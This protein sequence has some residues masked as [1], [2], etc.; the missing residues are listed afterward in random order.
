VNGEQ[1]Y[2][3][4]LRQRW[5]A[6]PRVLVGPGDDAAVLTWP[7]DRS[8]VVTT[9]MLMEGTCF[10]LAQAGARRVGRKALAVNLSDLAAMAA[11]PVACVVSVALPQVGGRAVAEEL[12][13]GMEE[14]SKA[15]DIPIVGGDTNSW[16][17][18][19]VIAVTAL[20]ECGP[21]G[22]VRR[23][24][25]QA[26]DW[27]LLTGPLGGS[28]LGHH[29]TFTPRVREAL[30]LVDLVRVHAMID[31]SDG[32]STDLAHLCQESDCG[33]CVE[34]ALLPIRPEA[35]QFDDGRSPLE[36]ALHDGEDFELLFAVSPEDGASLLADQPLQPLGVH[37]YRIGSCRSEKTLT[38]ILPDGRSQPLVPRGYEH[39]LD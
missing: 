29:L 26:G 32:L 34:A 36:H 5:V 6:H 9:D 14:L 35:E 31:I 18:P 7:S 12:Y 30:T 39:R 11:R 33:A 13:L 8:V 10:V 23:R 15:F 22:P 38:L 19:L 37:L 16:S 17:G 1:A 24:G 2:I 27:L 4:W 3:R 28:L 20:G 21:R 25:A